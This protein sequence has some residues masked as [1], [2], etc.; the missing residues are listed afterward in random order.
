MARK[1]PTVNTARVGN[2]AAPV[3]S[4]GD[5]AI[6]QTLF[7]P[8]GTDMN[9]TEAAYVAGAKNK[10]TAKMAVS[11]ARKANKAAPLKEY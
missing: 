9:A 7:G 6:D 8:K 4:T 1:D 2:Y 11:K 3:E 5:P 10:D